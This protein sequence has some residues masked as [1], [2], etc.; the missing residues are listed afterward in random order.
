MIPYYL[1]ISSSG[2]HSCDVSSLSIEHLYPQYLLHVGF[3]D[4]TVPFVVWAIN[5]H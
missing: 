1:K 3:L 4:V 5:T 2:L